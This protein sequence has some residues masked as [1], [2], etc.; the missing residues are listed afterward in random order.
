MKINR[1]SNNRNDKM[2]DLALNEYAICWM[3][4]NM[5]AVVDQQGD[6]V[7]SHPQPKGWVDFLKH[8]WPWMFVDNDD[9]ILF[10]I[11][12]G[13]DTGNYTLRGPTGWV[14]W[15]ILDE[16]KSKIGEI[17][18]SSKSAFKDNNKNT[19]AYVTARGFIKR[20]YTII[21]KTDNEI[22]AVMPPL[23]SSQKET[24]KLKNPELDNSELAKIFRPTNYVKIIDMKIS[25]ELRLFIL[26]F[27]I[28][29]AITSIRFLN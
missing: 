27:G 15:Y 14:V 1:N 23:L 6:T 2:T 16:N 26:A 24:F 25:K 22:L 9:N 20:E 7:Y 3:I 19:I 12:P 18:L 10:G 8:P 5:P 17:D 13:K 4:N 29:I 11:S 28:I 21:S